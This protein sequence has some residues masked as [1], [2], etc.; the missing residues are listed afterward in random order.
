MLLPMVVLFVS[1]WPEDH[2]EYEWHLTEPEVERLRDQGVHVVRLTGDVLQPPVNLG[3][4]LARA[5]FVWRLLR[6]GRQSDLVI[7]YMDSPST[8]VIA[9]LRVLGL[10]RRPLFTVTDFWLPPEGRGLRGVLK[11]LFLRR[12]YGGADVILFDTE[13]G[14]ELYERLGL[15]GARPLKRYVPSCAMAGK[16]RW[17]Q[18]RTEVVTGELPAEQPYF[19]AIGKTL[20]DFG[21]VIEAAKLVPEVRF[22]IMTP[23]T[24]GGL[25]ANVKQAPWGPF[26]DYLSALQGSAAV[27]IPL[28]ATV[29]AAGV[30][31]L[32]EAWALKV[33]TI[34]ADSEGIARYLVGQSVR[35]V[36]YRPGDAESLAAAVGRVLSEGD[37]VRQLVS[38][39]YVA[40]DSGELSSTAYMERFWKVVQLALVNRSRARLRS[41]SEGSFPLSE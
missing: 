30:R 31:S 10:L 1:W 21:T 20:R 29:D 15:L 28:P 33:P 5:R 18:S 38:D 19:F 11:R 14:L 17:L 23:K 4:L 2:F 41:P 34:V 27:I 9:I 25:P 35:S 12:V 26:D 7:G 40:T 39:A 16:V 22:V 36:L 37:R 13:P 8:R 24:L 32:Y 6:L 3:R